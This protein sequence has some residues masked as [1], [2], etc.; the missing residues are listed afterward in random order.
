M[1]IDFSASRKTGENK[2]TV[3]RKYTPEDIV[4]DESSELFSFGIT[5]NDI[6]GDRTDKANALLARQGLN[7]LINNSTEK[8]KNQRRTVATPYF[9]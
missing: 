6:V 7:D 8:R 9:K 5:L 1:L 2:V 4:N 3:T